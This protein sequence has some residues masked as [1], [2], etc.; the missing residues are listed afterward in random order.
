ME[1]SLHV[2]DISVSSVCQ[3]VYISLLSVSN[4]I[5]VGLHDDYTWYSKSY[6]A[7]SFSYHLKSSY[8]KNW[9]LKQ[10]EL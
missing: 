10:T 8:Q 7:V 5:R 2:Y 4:F 9:P 6:M 3:C 1:H